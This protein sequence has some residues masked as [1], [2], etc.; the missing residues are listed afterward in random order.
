MSKLYFN[1]VYILDPVSSVAIALDHLEVLT[2]FDP[3]KPFEVTVTDEEIHV[4]QKVTRTWAPGAVIQV[5]FHPTSKPYTYVRG[6]SGWLT[7]GHMP[8][9]DEYMSRQFD[10]KRAWDCEVVRANVARDLHKDD[11]YDWDKRY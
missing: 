4:N 8:I 7:D 10:E 9:S 5:Q 11:E 1:N 3:K 2:K 6:K